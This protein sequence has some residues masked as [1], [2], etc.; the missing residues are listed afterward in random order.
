MIVVFVAHALVAAALFYLGSRALITQWLW[1]RYPQRIATFMDCAAC[2]GFWYGFLPA[3][4]R[5]VHNGVDFEG[6]IT[7]I[8][9]GLCTLVTTPMLAALM[10]L[11]IEHLGS[12]VP[13]HEMCDAADPIYGQRCEHL[14][15]HKPPHES[16]E[17]T[18]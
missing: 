4:G 7:A 6:A 5:H 3:L 12:S 11:S 1:S 8:V 16:A 13:S 15:G 9:I 2:S 10:Q 17:G 14:V 18:W